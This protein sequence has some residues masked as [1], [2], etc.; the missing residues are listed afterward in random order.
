MCARCHRVGA[1][2]P[3]VG[4]DLTFVS[5]R[6]SRRDICESVLSPSKVVAEPW[7]MTQVTTSSG[8]IFAGRLISGGDFRSERIRLSTDPLRVTAVQE[9]DKTQIE[10]MR[11][12]ELSPMP[13]GLLNTFTLD[14]IR[15]LLAWLER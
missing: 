15:D 1:H 7:R 10:E 8:Q 11:T 12:M 3:A 2:G 14:E 4:Q 9:I 6:F 13:A 5:R